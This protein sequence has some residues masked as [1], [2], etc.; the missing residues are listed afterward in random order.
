MTEAPS[1]RTRLTLRVGVTG[2]RPNK[3]EL[4]DT[5]TLRHA[6]DQV[7][8][9]LSGIS[10]ALQDANNREGATRVYQ[11][12]AAPAL[13]LVTALA[14]GSDTI[15]AET[16]V[17]RG[18]SLNLILPY[19][20][21]TYEADFSADGLERFRAMTGHSAVTAACA[22]DGGDLPEPSAAYAAANEAM[23]EHTDVLI[24]V[25]DGEPAAGRGGT[26]EVVERAKARGQ[27]VIRVA[28]DGTVSLWQAAT[29]AVDPAADGTWIDPAS[30]PSGE[31]AALAAQFHRML[32]PP[33]DPTARSYLDAFLAESPCAS[34][35]ACGYKLLQGV[36]LGGSCHP[37]VEY[38]M[39]EK[40][41]HAWQP[42]LEAARDLGGEGFAAQLRDR[43][44]DRWLHADCLAVHYAHRYR[45]AF[46]TNFLLAAAAV[47]I[48]LLAVPFF[49][50]LTGKA[51]LVAAELGLIGTILWQTRVGHS[52]RWHERWLDYRN[53]A[54]ALRPARLAVLMGNS[55]RGAGSEVGKTPGQKWVAWYVRAVLREVEPPTGI[56]DRDALRRVIDVAT[57][58]EIDDQLAYHDQNEK[59]LEKLDHR[60]EVIGE[61]F[62]W[63]TLIAGGVYLL[64]Y[65]AYLL[66][67]LKAMVKTWKPWTTFLG[68]MLPVLGAAMFAIRATG[69]FRTAA[70][71]SARMQDELSG[72]RGKL[73]T[74][75]EA[76][77]DRH[78]VRHLL[79]EVTRSMA[80][81]LRVWGL[82][83]SERTLTPGF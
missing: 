20:K 65:V 83:Y 51:V 61:V 55:P 34:S 44:K 68:A 47:L 42:T 46:V 75:R 15:V 18:F 14:E 76:A 81:D 22:L 58:D 50:T 78:R 9:R 74:E 16:A 40:R 45:T 30:M 49:G 71:Q 25:W 21:A 39:T 52:A 67:D 72:L 64:S 62:L 8:E 29:N 57:S 37:R 73:I 7:L 79:N 66:F 11:E 60:L 77:P 36:L 10:Q 4:A 17:A 32:A 53:V 26:A 12:T 28:L 63:L 6:V 80:D 70:H 82:I 24:A 41:E 3:L 23:L 69:D 5:D 35:F 56:I 43:L 19:P 33:T 59:K 48:G 27:V 38:G 13:R 54:E 1:P 2:H 31:E